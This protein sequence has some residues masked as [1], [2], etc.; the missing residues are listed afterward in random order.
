MNRQEHERR[1][2]SEVRRKTGSVKK[3]GWEVKEK[4]ETN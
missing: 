3:V 2:R 1:G 4:S